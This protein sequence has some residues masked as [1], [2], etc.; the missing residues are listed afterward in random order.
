MGAQWCRDGDTSRP[1]LRAGRV[2]HPYRIAFSCGSS[3][4]SPCR[5]GIPPHQA[6]VAAWRGVAHGLCSR[7]AAV[8]QPP[9]LA[10]ES[11]IGCRHPRSAR[12]PC[13]CGR[14]RA[15]SAFGSRSEPGLPCPAP[16]GASASVP[17]DLHSLTPCGGTICRSGRLPDGMASGEA[18]EAAGPVIPGSER[19]P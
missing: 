16:S 5:S 12:A 9:A 10:A 7:L 4:K 13:R 1:P 18:P 3:S 6:A 2:A 19:E 8:S 15:L 14:Y 11:R 17:F